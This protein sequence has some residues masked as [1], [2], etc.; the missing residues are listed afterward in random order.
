MAIVAEI[1]SAEAAATRQAFEE[2]AEVPDKLEKAAWDPVKRLAFRL[3]KD[4]IRVL[5]KAEE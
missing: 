2:A 3:V 1:Q 5:A 4:R